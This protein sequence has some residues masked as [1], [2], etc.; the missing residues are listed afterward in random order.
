MVCLSFISSL[1]IDDCTTIVTV[2][3]C[4]IP[5]ESLLSLAV[6]APAIG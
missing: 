1:L 2:E 5:L 3:S 6:K 4:A